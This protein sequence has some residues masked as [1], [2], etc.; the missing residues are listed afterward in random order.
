MA[1]DTLTKETQQTIQAMAHSKGVK[2][3]EVMEHIERLI[4]GRKGLA[5]CYG[6]LSSPIR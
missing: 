1:Y 3:A 6:A 4:K 2:V 5:R